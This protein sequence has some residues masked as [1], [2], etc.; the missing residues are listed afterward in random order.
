MPLGFFD[1][2]VIFQK[3]WEVGGFVYMCTCMCVCVC[4]CV[5]VYVNMCLYTY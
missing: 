1:A 3:I 4:V 5:C 2:Y